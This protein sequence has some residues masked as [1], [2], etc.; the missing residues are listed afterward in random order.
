MVPWRVEVKYQVRI[1][2]T[3]HDVDVTPQSGGHFQ[4]TTGDRTFEV[5][6]HRSTDAEY[7]LQVEGETINFLAQGSPS[8]L[9]LLLGGELF[10]VET[11][12][13]RAGAAGDPAAAGPLNVRAVMPGLVREV[14][15]RPD[16][17]VE[18][19]VRL[20]VL[21]AMKMNNEIRAPRAGTV[22]A[23]RVAAGQRVDKGDVLVV[24]SS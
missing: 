20:L 16:D 17:Q 8:A 15:V 18:R 7:S 19:G 6:L 14:Y 12:P 23:V 1:G 4:V 21:E 2:D 24:L 10:A 5:T 22:Q 11:S 3:L 13:A 9:E